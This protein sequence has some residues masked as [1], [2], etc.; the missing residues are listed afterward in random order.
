[1]SILR[2]GGERGTVALDDEVDF[3]VGLET[4]LRRDIWLSF[5]AIFIRPVLFLYVNVVSCCFTLQA[6]DEI[7]SPILY[8]DALSCWLLL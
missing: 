8:R 5:H 7:A 3:G 4:W 6:A 1:M 2:E